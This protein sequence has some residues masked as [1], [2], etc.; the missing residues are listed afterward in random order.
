M[1]VHKNECICVHEFRYYLRPVQVTDKSVG[2]TRISSGNQTQFLW[3]S[4]KLFLSLSPLLP[5]PHTIFALD[6]FCYYSGIF[7][8]FHV[9]L[10]VHACVC[11][12]IRG[13]M[14]SIS[15][16]IILEVIPH[17]SWISL[18]LSYWLIRRNPGH[19]CLHL[20]SAEMTDP[21][22]PPDFF[23]GWWDKNKVVCLCITLL[24]KWSISQ[25]TSSV[26]FDVLR[27]ICLSSLSLDSTS[28][29]PVSRMSRRWVAVDSSLRFQLSHEITKDLLMQFCD[30]LS[31]G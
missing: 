17:W 26:S 3:K 5:L 12:H 8:F 23:C 10:S 31:L 11:M 15:I 6:L 24:T 21:C 19:P 4:I 27:L 13:Q 22:C 2:V 30:T 16:L 20:P 7:T 9:F 14:S 1:C 28:F 25:A 18:L 29:L